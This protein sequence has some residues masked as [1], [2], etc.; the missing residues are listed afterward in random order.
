[1]R[2]N[3][4]ILNPHIKVVQCHVIKKTCLHH[5]QKCNRLPNLVEQSKVR[6]QDRWVIMYPIKGTRSILDGDW[7]VYKGR[8]RGRPR[9][10]EDELLLVIVI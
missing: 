4:K 1:M 6:R 8:R 9:L 2:T 7:R 3:N 10:Q 5:C